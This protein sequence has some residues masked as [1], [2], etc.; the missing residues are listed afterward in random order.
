M[1]R[2]VAYAVDLDDARPGES[3]AASQQVDPRAG[4]P[5]LL[6]GVGVVGD[7]EVAPGE[8]RGDIDLRIGRRVA[9]GV[10]GLAR[11][12]Q[13]LGRDAGPVGAL[14]A[15]ELALG[16]RDVQSRGGQRGGGVLAGRAAADDDDVV[17]AHA[18]IPCAVGVAVRVRT[19]TCSTSSVI[20][21]KLW[22]ALPCSS[23]RCTSRRVGK[24]NPSNVRGW[25][26]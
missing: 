13:R 18:L 6:A 14:A 23:C 11:A 26:V 5:V 7:H 22:S 20:G 8:R 16:E 25:C 9:R 4:Q 3:A 21:A 2:G 1:L 19:V 24:T 17:V 12:Q 15:D 10:D